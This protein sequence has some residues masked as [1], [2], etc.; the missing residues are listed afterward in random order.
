MKLLAIHPLTALLLTACP[1]VASR[2]AFTYFRTLT[3][4]SHEFPQY[5]G[6]GNKALTFFV[7]PF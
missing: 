5:G 7:K 2:Q 4:A 1:T 6:L 3:N